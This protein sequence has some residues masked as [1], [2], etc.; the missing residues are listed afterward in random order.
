MIHLP[1]T[2]LVYKPF[3]ILQTLGYKNEETRPLSPGRIPTEV[4]SHQKRYPSLSYT[5]LPNLTFSQSETPKFSVYS[6]VLPHKRSHARPQPSL[7]ESQE[8]LAVDIAGVAIELKG[9][10]GQRCERCRI[11]W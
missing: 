2:S 5:S 6:G 11:D 4:T 1:Y 3:L 10:Q 9:I 8:H 7:N